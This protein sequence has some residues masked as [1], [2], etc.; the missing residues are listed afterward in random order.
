MGRVADLTYATYEDEAKEYL[1]I[2]DTDWD[3]TLE[4]FWDA[5]CRKADDYL[6]NPFEEIVPTLVFADVEA[7][8]RV[9]IN[10]QVFTAAA[11]TDADEREFAVGTDDDTDADELQDLVNSNIM[12]GSEGAVGIDGITAVNTSGS[13]TFAVRYPNATMAV[14]TSSNDTRLKI[15]NVR[16]SSDVPHPVIMWLFQFM[17][18]KFA[19]RDGRKSER[20]AAMGTIEWGDA[21][22]MALLALY[23]LSPG[24]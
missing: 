4:R 15:T 7:N 1:W 9:T 3:T 14:V 11:A 8:D 24:I 22:E 6:C 20:I 21:P 16:T 10:D 18:W 2:D 13:I 19:N 23:R 5:A 12:G 17:A